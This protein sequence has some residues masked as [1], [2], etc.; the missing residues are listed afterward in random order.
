LKPNQGALNARLPDPAP[1]AGLPTPP[2]PPPASQDTLDAG[3]LPSAAPLAAPLA[4][5]LPS[6]APWIPAP[7]ALA[8]GPAQS[9]KLA[10]CCAASR[11]TCPSCQHTPSANQ[12]AQDAGPPHSA[13]S[14]AGL[15]ALSTVPAQLL[16][17]QQPRPLRLARPS[18]LNPTRLPPPS[19]G[20]PMLMGLYCRAAARPTSA[21]IG[22]IA[23]RFSASFGA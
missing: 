1:P 5:P 11:A 2:R 3:P 22:Q 12:D 13:P 6:A 18:R 9:A 10:S 7:P 16:Q 19:A 17:R 20:V 8:G 14:P 21:L 23:K 15:P 4:G